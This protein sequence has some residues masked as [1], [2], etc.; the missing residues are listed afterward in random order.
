[1]DT[2]PYARCRADVG[3][4]IDSIIP[5]RFNRDS[6]S[7][8]GDS[9]LHRYPHADCH[10][11]TY[12]D[13]YPHANLNSDL[14]PKRYLYADVYRDAYPQP[15]PDFYA[16]GNPDVNVHAELDRNLYPHTTSHQHLDTFIDLYPHR[17]AR[18][19]LYRGAGIALICRRGG[20]CAA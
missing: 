6:D 15:D 11:Y 9:N 18:R 4:R 12:R 7:L 14:Y 20:V 5:A 10:P 16:D 2:H 8:D 13:S 17:A 19:K 3:G 1:M